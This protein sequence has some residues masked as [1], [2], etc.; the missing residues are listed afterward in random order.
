MVNAEKDRK[1][2]VGGREKTVGG[3]QGLLTKNFRIAS[4]FGRF[5][6]Q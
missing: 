3:I 5:N 6:K 4:S 1:L 2:R